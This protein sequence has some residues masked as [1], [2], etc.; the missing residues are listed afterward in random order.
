M[1]E[2]L[3]SIRNLQVAFH[4]R[5]STVQAVGGID[6]D[7]YPGETVGIVGES[8]SGKSVTML[9]T[10]GLLPQTARVTVSGQILLRGQDLLQ[11]PSQEFRRIRGRDMALIPQD[12][13]TCLDPVLRVG[14]QLR[15]ALGAHQRLT[16][17]QARIRSIELLRTVGIP[18]PERRHDQFP[19]EFSG[20]MRQRAMIAMGMANN[21]ALLIADEP[22]TALDVTVQAQI[23]DVLRMAQRQTQACLAL[24]THDL[25]LIAEM[26]D[27]VIVMYAGRI[28]E[29]GDVR[30]IFSRP[31]HPYTRGLMASL[32]QSTDVR[33][34]LRPIPGSPPDLGAIPGGCP[35]HP[36]CVLAQ[37]RE[38]CRSEL[39]LLRPAGDTDAAAAHRSACHFLEELDG[40]HALPVPPQETP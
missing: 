30:T 39:P 9:A 32:P 36:R 22:T 16:R 15:E 37:G 12:P 40:G 17:R 28:V 23:M 33:Q 21:P 18:E 5:T 8:G 1:T 26:A 3:L 4:S 10:M 11:M 13:M 19:H 6:L 29:S 34:P 20:G 38:R 14:A 31:R 24:I 35:F 25:G 7:I 27:R 2:P